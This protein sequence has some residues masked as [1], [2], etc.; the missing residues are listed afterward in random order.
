MSAAAIR[1]TLGFIG[2]VGSLIFVGIEIQQ[3][4]KVARAAAYQEIGFTAADAYRT[5]SLDREWAE[6]NLLASD[7]TK[8][9][10]D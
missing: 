1:E 8:W 7:S 4:T 9:R 5:M 2:V 10:E 6:L 3:N